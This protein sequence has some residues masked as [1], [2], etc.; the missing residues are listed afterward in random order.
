V[1]NKSKIILKDLNPYLSLYHQTHIKKKRTNLNSLKFFNIVNVNFY[2]TYTQWYNKRLAIIGRHISEF[3]LDLKPF[4]TLTPKHVVTNENI[5]LEFKSRHKRK[6]PFLVY[7]L[8]RSVDKHFNTNAAKHFKQLKQTKYRLLTPFKKKKRKNLS[9]L[10]GKII[11]HKKRI[12]K[13]IQKHF[14]SRQKSRI[15]KNNL[16]QK[17][18]THFFTLIKS[19]YQKSFRKKSLI[20]THYEFEDNNTKSIHRNPYNFLN[21]KSNVNNLSNEVQDYI[22]NTLNNSL[23]NVKSSYNKRIISKLY[24]K[25]KKNKQTK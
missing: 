2:D 21:N 12:F 18:I 15:R 13:K 6:K 24:K 1:F 8:S 11:L 3:S 9:L 20:S 19:M 14:F 23:E 16:K 7:N 10:R 4:N 22:S 25:L 5:K 17:T